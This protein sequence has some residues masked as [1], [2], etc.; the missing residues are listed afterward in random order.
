MVDKE[1]KKKELVEKVTGEIG[2]ALKKTGAFL[3]LLVDVDD[4]DKAWKC[5]SAAMTMR[6][7]VDWFQR[8]SMGKGKSSSQQKGPQLVK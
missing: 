8:T 1:R 6:Y 2:A 7:G 4:V 5:V 3:E